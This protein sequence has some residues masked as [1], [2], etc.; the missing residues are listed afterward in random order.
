VITAV[1]GRT[2]TTPNSLTGIM[3]NFRPGS[4]V[5]LTF[6]AVSTGQKETRTLILGAKPPV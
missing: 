2:V 4:H 3:A 1:N 5:K 6:I